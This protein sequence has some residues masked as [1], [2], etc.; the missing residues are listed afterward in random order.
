[1]FQLLVLVFA[2]AQLMERLIEK[3]SKLPQLLL[4]E[5]HTFCWQT[6]ASNDVSRYCRFHYNQ[7]YC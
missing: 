5:N 6:C 1:M 2:Q 3:I 7:S 4:K